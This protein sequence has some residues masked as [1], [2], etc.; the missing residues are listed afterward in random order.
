MEPDTPMSYSGAF[1][2]EITPLAAGES[3]TE[4]LADNHTTIALLDLLETAPHTGRENERRE[5]V[6]QELLRLEHKLDLVLAMLA[7]QQAA[8]GGPRLRNHLL[9]REGLAWRGEAACEARQVVQVAL[10]PEPG[11]PQPLVLCA[12]IRHCDAGGGELVFEQVD[13]ES[14]DWLMRFLFRHH[15]RQVAEARAREAGRDGS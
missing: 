7:R 10:Y 13:A 5:P 3:C 15:R 6:M 2:L 12:R 11:C 4:P 1:P 8:N 9:S 14:A